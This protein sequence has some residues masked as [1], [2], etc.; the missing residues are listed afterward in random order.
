MTTASTGPPSREQ[1]AIFIRR[2]Q[3]L[4]AL[5]RAAEEEQTRLLNSKCSHKL[6][7]QK[8][9]AL[10]GLGVASVSLGLGGKRYV[11]KQDNTL[12]RVRKLGPRFVLTNA[13]SGRASPTYSLPHQPRLSLAHLS[14]RR[15][16]T[17]GGF[18]RQR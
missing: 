10:G 15:S 5:E 17:L 4:L 2:L 6:L 3:E 13:Q 16:R 14:Q 12:L 7:E 18:Q 1:L 11:W 8:G 9:L